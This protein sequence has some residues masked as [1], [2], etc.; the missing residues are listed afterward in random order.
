MHQPSKT[1]HVSHANPRQYAELPTQHRRVPLLGH[2]YPFEPQFNEKQSVAY[3][4]LSSNPP[5]RSP[6]P[7]PL[8]IIPTWPPLPHQ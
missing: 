5:I 3:S 7:P 6:Y 1:S 4:F 2:T 8:M